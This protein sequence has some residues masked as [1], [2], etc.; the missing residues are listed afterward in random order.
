MTESMD[1]DGS[2]E[3]DIMKMMKEPHSKSET[4]RS[5]QIDQ[6]T[7]KNAGTTFKKFQT[8]ILQK[9][10]LDNISH[11]Y[12][13]KDDKI[14][15]ANETGLSKKQITG[16][17]TNNRKRK[18][19]KVAAIAKKKNKDFN[20]VRDIIKMKFDKDLDQSLSSNTDNAGETDSKRNSEVTQFA[21]K[22][23][24]SGNNSDKQQI[25][26]QLTASKSQI[27]LLQK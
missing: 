9:W 23:W 26:S 27:E 18:Y 16:W 11:P 7:E 8:K 10:F 2:E 19:Q 21:K 1:Q 6:K 17:F 25:I 4:E 15:L 14:Q 20:Y 5:H 24:G 12:L 22:I 13:K 3:I